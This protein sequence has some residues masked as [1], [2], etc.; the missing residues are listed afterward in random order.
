MGVASG[1]AVD[2]ERECM[3]PRHLH[4]VIYEDGELNNLATNMATPPLSVETVWGGAAG[5]EVEK[6]M[7]IRE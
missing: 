3:F 2:N 6:S 1:V 4:L 5:H 7:G